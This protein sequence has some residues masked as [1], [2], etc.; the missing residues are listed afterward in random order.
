MKK[1]DF[2]HPQFI[3][4]TLEGP[5]EGIQTVGN[6]YF[7]PAFWM[8][9]QTHTAHDLISKVCNLTKRPKQSSSI[10]LTGADMENL[11]MISKK[12]KN[13][14][15][16]ALVTAGVQ[17]NAMRMSKDEGL[18]FKAGTIN[19]IIMSNRK[20]S[21]KAMTRAIITAT[22]AKTAAL[23][24]MDIRSA[25]TP[26]IHPATGTGTDNI[27]V[28]QGSIGTLID[29]TG[30]HTKAG[31]L[32][33]KA[34]YDGVQQAIFKQNGISVS[35][36]IFFRLKERKVSLNGLLYSCD[37]NQGN[38]KKL[39]TDLEQMLLDPKYV[40]F[41]EMALTFSDAYSQK[42]ISRL[43]PFETLCKALIIEHTNKEVENIYPFVSDSSIPKPLEMAINT[44]LQ[45]ADKGRS[46][47]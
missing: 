36:S 20:L 46:E 6:H 4:S 26:L 42:Q 11:V 10:L 40:S 35:R 22:E 16:H 27:I 7:E 5:K 30:G 33:A 17:S 18:Y 25:Y 32:I 37:C 1:I 23:Q 44:L 9:S 41:V 2:N 3:L 31:A 8:V 47:K 39:K 28:V 21:K 19:I 24:D 12:H 15:I 13:L 34:V 45:I 38:K 43:S 29:Q 14:T